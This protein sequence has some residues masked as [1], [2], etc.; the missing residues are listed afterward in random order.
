MGIQADYVRKI[1]GLLATAESL[2]EQG[3]DEDSQLSTQR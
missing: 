2:A 3:N 1:Q